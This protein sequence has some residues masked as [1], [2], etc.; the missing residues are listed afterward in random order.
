MAKGEFEEN[1]LKRRIYNDTNE[2]FKRNSIER[3]PR[4]TAFVTFL[5]SVTSDATIQ[6]EVFRFH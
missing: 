1:E 6:S 2:H 4:I 3:D 5:K